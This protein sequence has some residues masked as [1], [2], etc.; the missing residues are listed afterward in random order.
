MQ[1]T[2][3]DKMRRKRGNMADDSKYIA[4]I[5]YTKYGKYGSTVEEEAA[6]MGKLPTNSIHNKH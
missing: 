2:G 5:P 3:I 1:S 6:K 4:Y